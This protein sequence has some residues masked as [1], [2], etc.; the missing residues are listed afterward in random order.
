MGRK[1]FS[2]KMVKQGGSER[3]KKGEKKGREGGRERGKE[4][5]KIKKS[6]KE[7]LSS[8][9]GGESTRWLPTNDTCFN[10]SMRSA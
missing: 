7:S 3:R 9:H 8:L 6:I 5:G 10:S 2:K 4:E 1:S